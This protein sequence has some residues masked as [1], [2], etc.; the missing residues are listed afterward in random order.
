MIITRIDIHRDAPLMVFIYCIILC[1]FCLIEFMDSNGKNS[2]NIII[3]KDIDE[4]QG[5]AQWGSKQKKYE[6]TCMF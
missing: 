2:Y 6:K 4:K 3:N 5:I 1:M